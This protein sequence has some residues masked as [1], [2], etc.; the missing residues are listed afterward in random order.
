[1]ENTIAKAAGNGLQTNKG[2]KTI[3][4]LIKVMA[5]EIKKALPAVITPERFTRMVLSALSKTPE[6]QQC[7]PQ[8]FLGAMMTAAQLGLEPNTPLGQAYILPFRNHGKYEC[9]FQ[10]GY[11]GLL[12]LAWRT[13]RI[14]SF[15]VECI[16]SNDELEYE[17]GLKP[18]LKIKPAAGDRGEVTHYYAIIKMKDDAEIFAV[19]SKD[20][21]I[22]HAKKYSQSFNSSFSPWKTS[23]DEMA[24]KT[25]LK[26]VL[27]YAPKASEFARAVA[28][29]EVI[30]TEISDDMYTVVDTTD[31][32]IVDELPAVDP[33]TGE[34]TG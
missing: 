33:D 4:D 1:M 15:Q 31:Y 9:Q 11:Q 17:L 2:K 34:V 5:P 22:N 7:S 13:E 10:I 6:L 26:R 32:T 14:A 18:V 29:D 28:Q 8:S 19:M 16:Y 3:Q 24:K 23:F 21:I 20:E 12:E 27:K 25:V 30:K